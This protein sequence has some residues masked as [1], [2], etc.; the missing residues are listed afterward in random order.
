[1]VV[2]ELLI[3]APETLS[4][5]SVQ[6]QFALV[7]L[8]DFLPYWSEEEME[9]ARKDG[10]IPVFETWKSKLSSGKI[11]LDAVMNLSALFAFITDQGA[12]DQ[13][14]RSLL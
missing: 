7:G 4:P 1:M 10:K 5:E 9:T 6:S 14:I 3:K 8:G 12:L 11:G 2:E 13:H